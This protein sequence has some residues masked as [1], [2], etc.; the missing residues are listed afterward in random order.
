MLKSLHSRSRMKT[1]KTRKTAWICRKQNCGKSF[2]CRPSRWRHEKTCKEKSPDP[3][4][5]PTALKMGDNK[6]RCTACKT[7]YIGMESFSR[8]KKSSDTKPSVCEKKRQKGQ[9]TVVVVDKDHLPHK[10]Q[11]CGKGFKTP[12]KLARHWNSIHKEKDNSG[13]AAGS[14]ELNIE[15]DKLEAAYFQELRKI[16]ERQD[17]EE[18]TCTQPEPTYYYV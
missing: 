9:G 11:D 16:L 5:V 12:Y 3:E 18:A 14:S 10:C 7:V 2:A 1:R 17:S 15:S 6:I 13:S 8:H 4:K